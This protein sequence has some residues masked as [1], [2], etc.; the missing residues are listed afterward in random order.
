[1]R[2]TVIA[3]NWKMHMTCAETREFAAVLRPLIADLPSNRQVV[4]APPF[5]SIPTLCR[6]LEGAGVA[7]AAQNVHWEESG[8]YTGMVSAPMLVE[9]GVSH[10]IVGHS[11]PRKYY[12]ETDEQINLRARTAQRFGLIPILCVGE[13][14]DQREARETERVI[15]RQIEQGLEGV[16]PLR[17]IVAYEPI[18]AIGTGRTASPEQAV[19]LN[20]A[21]VKL[22]AEHRKTTLALREYRSPITPKQVTVVRQQNVSAGDQQIALVESCPVPTST[23]KNHTD[24]E[25]GS[26]AIAYV[27]P[28]T[29]IPQSET[30]G[31]RKAEPVT[32][33]RSDRRRSAAVEA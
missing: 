31:R 5:T 19:T 1:M 2:R 7:I 23:E 10:A 20:M 32:S 26:R 18:W 11:E 6:H 21:A 15:H 33:P 4:L 28:E 8:A 24:S 3:G 14:L 25:Q 9:H 16:D 30:R 13:S 22:M 17:V 12:S 27:E 29:I